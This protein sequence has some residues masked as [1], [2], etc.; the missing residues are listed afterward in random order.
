MVSIRSSRH[1]RHELKVSHRS[2]ICTL[3]SACDVI[4]CIFTL[5]YG[6]DLKLLIPFYCALH[7][8]G[9]FL[10]M[11]F[12]A[13]SVF[14][15]NGTVHL[16]WDVGSTSCIFSCLCT[17]TKNGLSKFFFKVVFMLT[18]VRSLKV[19]LYLSISGEVWM[20]SSKNCNILWQFMGRK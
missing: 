3:T 7:F 1:C 10:Y 12:P 14:T 13:R 15:V 17:T 5:F 6:S 16:K 2:V 20:L 18:P 11:S 9:D 8:I 19:Q 4:S